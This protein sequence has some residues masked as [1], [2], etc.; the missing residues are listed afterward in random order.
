MECLTK[1]MTTVMML[2][3]D[4]ESTVIAKEQSEGVRNER[5]ESEV[6]HG[7]LSNMYITAK[8]IRICVKVC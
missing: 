4:S 5:I 7:L 6:L 2:I 1:P 8:C 3:L